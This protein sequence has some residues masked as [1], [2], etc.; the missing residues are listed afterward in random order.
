MV[1]FEAP[2]RKLNYY[3][4]FKMRF[5]VFLYS[6]NRSPRKF[7]P[8]LTE[9]LFMSRRL[10]LQWPRPMDSVLPSCHDI[11]NISCNFPCISCRWKLLFI[12]LMPCGGQQRLWWWRK[13]GGCIVGG[14]SCAEATFDGANERN[15]SASMSSSGAVAAGAVDSACLEMSI[16][17]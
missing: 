9:P 7:N 12:N 4:F 10:S 17:K 11:Y 16:C 14:S 2:R 1:L 3:N 6:R 13:R 5:Y 8:A 15:C